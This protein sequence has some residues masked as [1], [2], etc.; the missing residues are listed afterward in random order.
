MVVPSAASRSTKPR[1]DRPKRA[2]QLDPLEPR[3]AGVSDVSRSSVDASPF[4]DAIQ[5][6][7]RHGWSARRVAGFLVERYSGVPELVATI[8]SAKAI[9]R[10][11]RKNLRAKDILP[12]M[13][14]DELLG[15]TTAEIDV[16]GELQA[17]APLLANRLAGALKFEQGLGVTVDAVDRAAKTYL[18]ALG[19]VWRIGQGLG[20]YPDQPVP[21]HLLIDA[22]EPAGLAGQAR[23]EQPPTGLTSEEST[24]VHELLYKMRHREELP[25]LE[26]LE[27]PAAK[28]GR[29]ALSGQPDES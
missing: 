26:G 2:V 8:P 13:L 9:S 21:R 10:W 18:A 3:K 7:L 27:S 15:R 19:M 12:P 24:A 28:V 20:F 1:G 14:L 29:E 23:A 6:L 25:S 17:L 22:I 4:R 11:A 16:M 5:E